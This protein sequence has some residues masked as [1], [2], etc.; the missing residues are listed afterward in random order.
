MIE[1]VEF[2]PPLRHCNV[3]PLPSR[4]RVWAHVDVTAP[5]DRFSVPE[6]K[7]VFFFFPSSADKNACSCNTKTSSV[8]SDV[9]VTTFVPLPEMATLPALGETCRYFKIIRQRRDSGRGVKDLS[10]HRFPADCRRC[11]GTCDLL[12][13]PS[14]W[15]ASPL[16]DSSPPS[17]ILICAIYLRHVETRE[18]AVEDGMDSLFSGPETAAGLAQVSREERASFLVP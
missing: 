7:R 1:E 4:G 13:S 9:T 5:L 11:R 12:S 6:R 15:L 16:D 3:Y 2:F 8:R 17:S 14:P 18:S 10:G